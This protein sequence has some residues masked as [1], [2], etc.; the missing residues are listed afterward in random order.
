MKEIV[1][2]GY[3]VGQYETYFR[4]S[5]NPR[6]FERAMLDKALTERP[7]GLRVLDLGCG[8]GIPYGH[9]LDK[10]GANLLGIDFC[11]R[12]LKLAADN[13]PHAQFVMGDLSQVDFPWE[14]F[15]LITSFYAI[16]HLPREE[17]AVIFS[18]IH[19]WLRQGG[20]MLVTLGTSDSSYAEETDWCGADR[21]AWSTYSP[22]RY[23]EIARETG[24]SL[25]EGVYEGM[26]GD[27]EHH[28]WMLCKKG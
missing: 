2:R 3:E 6:H 7:S 27:E 28:F 19:A 16:F 22:E 1:R 25:I 8:T 11:W 18:R 21:M 12:H 4:T 17:H 23:V 9:Y 5:L 14:S 10:Q 26:P 20:R 24:F 15:D 13:V